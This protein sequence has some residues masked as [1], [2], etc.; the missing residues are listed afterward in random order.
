MSPLIQSLGYPP[1]EWFRDVLYPMLV[2]PPGPQP[3]TAQTGESWGVQRGWP[4]YSSTRN[5]PVPQVLVGTTTT[6]QTDTTFL[7]QSG[8]WS[9]RVRST[10]GAGTAQSAMFRLPWYTPALN[11][12]TAPARDDPNHR[13]G[14]LR[15]Y[16][17]SGDAVAA[18]ANADRVGVGIVP[19]DGT[20]TSALVS[21]PSQ[22]GGFGVYK[23]LGTS[24]WR[25]ASYSA[26]PALLEGT[27]MTPTYAGW[28][29][30]DFI[31]RQAR[32]G[33]PST[34][35]LTV[36]HD[37]VDLF[38]ER[39]F[40]TALLPAPSAIRANAGTFALIAG[41]VTGGNPFAFSWAARWRQGSF[42]PDGYPQP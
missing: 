17:L 11:L 21:F 15:V 7:T 37:G 6:A 1:L 25:Y 2:N 42:H 26:A 35:W 24:D 9:H 14:W 34:P 3:V 33:D 16:L 8:R 32:G 38:R 13:I 40:G 10:G 30:V 31:I 23:I 27:A 41:T 12:A 4:F 20:P 39:P 22:A 36:R 29:T 5:T 28:H 19:D 18:G